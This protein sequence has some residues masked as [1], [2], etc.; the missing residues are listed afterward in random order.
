MPTPDL[1]DPVRA[2]LD[3]LAGYMIG[4]AP[5]DETLAH[6]ATVAVSAFPAARFA[7]LSTLVDGEPR[8]AVF[9]DDE[10]P[11]ID[12]AQYEADHGP[13]LDAYR[14]R[15]IYRVNDTTTETQWVA[16]AR[17]AADHGIRSTISLP[18]VANGEGIGALNL[19][20]SE[21][22]GFADAD[23]DLGM[24]LA[25]QAAVVLA[26]S[27]AYWDAYGLTQTLQEAMRSRATVEQATGILMSTERC[28]SDEA[29]AMLVRASSLEDRTL[30]DVAS[31]IVERAQPRDPD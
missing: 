29:F 24:A 23:D 22:A 17:A 3:A 30:R 5:L 10:A 28:T 20:S 9:T 11:E 8:T 15:E 1:E 2:A 25:T 6:V 14:D 7:G 31:E 26:N 18:L 4:S 13:C 16:F 21:V 27:Q 12:S 19:Y